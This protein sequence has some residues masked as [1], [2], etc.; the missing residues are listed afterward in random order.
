[1]PATLQESLQS[2]IRT[3]I[4][5]RYD[6]KY[7]IPQES[8][9]P[10]PS[11]S[12]LA[13]PYFYFLSRLLAETIKRLIQE[14]RFLFP[15]R[16]SPLRQLDEQLSAAQVLVMFNETRG[17]EA[18]KL[19][20]EIQETIKTMQNALATSYTYWHCWR[21]FRIL[22][23]HVPTTREGG[24]VVDMPSECCD[25][26]FWEWMQKLTGVK[27]LFGLGGI[28]TYQYWEIWTG[29]DELRATWKTGRSA[30]SGPSP[31]AML[32]PRITPP[33]RT[34]TKVKTAPKLKTPLSPWIKADSLRKVAPKQR[35]LIIFLSVPADRF[36]AVL[37]R[38]SAGAGGVV[39]V[40]QTPTTPPETLSLRKTWDYTVRR[41]AVGHSPLVD[42]HGWEPSFLLTD[43]LVCVG[44]G[45]RS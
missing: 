18:Q 36:R 30:A 21:L 41:A 28:E 8:I 20:P 16:K 35:S 43:L 9:G 37:E 11:S 26:W 25:E 1:M 3:L 34:R 6:G 45:S 19:V 33:R 32:Q 13:G 15:G 31:G 40:P 42:K 27:G 4:A 22:M 5:N 17:D 44:Q 10:A 2:L 29:L 24:Q 38:C 12:S 39:T 14:E 23:Q 7:A